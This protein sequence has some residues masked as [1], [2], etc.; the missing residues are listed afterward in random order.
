MQRAPKAVAP[1]ASLSRGASTRVENV[2]KE[3]WF[4]RSL[5]INMND[6][7]VFPRF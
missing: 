3:P 2:V 4:C 1:A 5:E 6:D 7:E